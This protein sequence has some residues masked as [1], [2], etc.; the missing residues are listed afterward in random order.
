MEHRL[1]LDKEEYGYD[2]DETSEDLSSA[3]YKPFGA[4]KDLLGDKD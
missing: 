3:G 4:L 1:N 2:A